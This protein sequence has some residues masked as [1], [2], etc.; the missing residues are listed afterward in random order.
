MNQGWRWTQWDILFVML[1]AYL[2]SLPM[3]ETYKKII[4]KKRAE[5]QGVYLPPGPPPRAMLKVLVM[6]TLTRPIRMLFIEP[7]VFWYSLYISFNFAVLFAFFAAFPIVFGE[8]YHF[9]IGES[10]L[11]FLAIG[12]GCC[13]AAI[14]AI[15]IDRVKYQ[16]E[17]RKATAEGRN[18]VAPEHRLY[19]AMIGSFG[20]PIGVGGATY[21][22]RLFKAR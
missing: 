5:R 4:L 13:L 15:I 1:T 14:T 17:Q 22:L 7:I 12:F 21:N 3:T 19:A 9:N 10:G 16:K 2:I 6:V 20:L 18:A 8:V 11:P